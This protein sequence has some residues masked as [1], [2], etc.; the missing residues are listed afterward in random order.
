MGG[1][2]RFFLPFFLLCACFGAG[3]AFAR[4]V[5]NEVY[6]DHPGADA[7]YEFVELIDTDGAAADIGGL[8]LEFHNGTGTGWVVLWRAEPGV[9]IR[10]GEPFLLGDAMVSPAP[11]VLTTLSLQN[12]PDA[13]R[14]VDASG[15]VLDVVGYGGLDD[16]AYTETRGAA[17]VAAGMSIARVP[18]ANDTGDN[19]SDFA[20]AAP[21]P[22]RFNVPRRDVALALAP[23][24]PA[25]L[26]RD[27]PGEERIALEVVNTGV[28][29]VD[30]GQVRVAIADSTEAGS[31]E[32]AVVVNAAVIPPGGAER[33]ELRV[34]LSLGFHRLAATAGYPADERG[35]NDTV[36]LLRRVGRVPVLVSE[37][38]SAPAP[39]CPQ[40]V[41]VFN[42]GDAPVDVGGWRL[43]DMRA[44]PVPIAA[45]SLVIAPRGFLAVSASPAALIACVPQTP[46]GSVVGVD[47]SWP[48]FNRSG[49]GVADSVVVSD[50]HGI[51]VEAVAYP[52]LPTGISG[53][54]IERVD[55]Y[56]G[57]RAPVWRL[58]PAAQGCSPGRPNGASLYDPPVEGEL[59]VEPNPFA[60]ARGDVLRIAVAAGAG[61]A[62]VVVSVFDMTGRRVADVG[63]AFALPAVFLWDGRDRSGHT[64]RPGLYVVACEELLADGT[65]GTVQKVVVGCA[66]AAR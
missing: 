9:T 32:A 61:V 29:A 28:L 36:V 54:S 5:I 46:P 52:P 56:P 50:R 2:L 64:V 58:S 43:R 65:R 20:A 63:S 22:G 44:Q 38:W 41:E 51:P 42:A 53:V 33:V 8:T 59:D 24:T 1:V 48:S 40:F 60:P 6:Y 13:L 27:A 4:V 57:A 55:L 26:G 11:D 7:G 45:D 25:L 14:I 19:A 39:Q 31:V 30:A 23:P 10:A 62:R 35:F 37:V 3:R 17:V 16:A 12:G 34:A 18:D 21:S 47:G 49:S 66:G 15:A